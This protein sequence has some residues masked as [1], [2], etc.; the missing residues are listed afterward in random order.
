MK[1]NSFK[2]INRTRNIQWNIMSIIPLLLVFVFC[3]IPMFGLVIAFKNYKYNKGIFG[4]DWVGLKHFE[5]FMKSNDFVRITW[6]TLYLNFV[7]II[8]GVIAA[9]TLAIFL[10][11]LK[12]AKG[13]KTYQTVLMTPNFISW[14][15]VGYMVYALLNPQYGIVNGVLKAVGFQGIDWYSKPE[16]W[17]VILT[18]ANVWKNVGLD[19][20][21]YYA[22][23]MSLDYSLMEAADIDGAGY[24]KKVMNIIIPSLVPTIVTL[25]ILKIGSI[26]RADFGLFYQ[27]PRDVGAL[28]ATTDVIDTYIYR[29]MRIVGDMSLSTAVGLLQSVV[30]AV[31][32]IIT[33]AITRKID[34]NLSLF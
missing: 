22:T 10:Y 2:R 25:T 18:I 17:P 13:I 15:I 14:V 9:V 3:Y 30:S 20:I 12:S 6:N 4:S 28:Y 26:F 31:L 24:M 34:D 21:Y 32:V 5:A 29:T 11:N 27:L 8:F 23:L 19:S 16:V 1:Q 33:N 7:F